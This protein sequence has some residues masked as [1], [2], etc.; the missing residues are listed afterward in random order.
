V[1]LLN[2]GPVNVSSRVKAALGGPDICH[3]EPEYSELQGAIRSRLLE[4]FGISSEQ[5]VSVLLTGSGTAAVEAM[6]ASSIPDGGRLLVIENGTYGQRMVRMA[7]AHGIECDVLTAAW[8]ERAATAK[9]EQLLAHSRYEG[10][11]LVHHETTTGLLNAL[12]PI[13]TLCA[14]YGVP[15]LVDAV[16]SLGGERLDVASL[17]PSAISATSNKCLGSLPGISF[18]LVDRELMGRMSTYRERSV[19][20]HLPR[21]FEA[22]EQRS[23]AFTP[24]IPICY[25]LLAALDELVEETLGRRQARFA[26]ASMLIRAGLEQAGFEMLLP[27]ELRSATLTAVKIPHHLTYAELHDA[28][29][30]EGFVVYAGQGPDAATCFRVATMGAVPEAEYR[31]F[32]DVA[33]RMTMRAR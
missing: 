32:V 24:S 4:V 9:L 17:R 22:Q 27:P 21:H 6:I 20:L 33:G 5:Y 23:T 26:H 12:E 25:A 18:V 2:P 1:I 30:D 10:L 31:R 8:T 15:V 29:K 16:S 3:R 28:L 7:R 14:Q 19:Y 13:S 11:A